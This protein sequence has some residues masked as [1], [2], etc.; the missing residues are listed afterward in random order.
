MSQALTIGDVINDI[1]ST[2]GVG[3][4]ASLNNNSIQLTDN[5]GQTTTALAVSNV[6]STATATGLGLTAASSGATLTGNQINSIGANTLLST[7]N[8]GNGVGIN[9][10]LA[11]LTV[12]RSDGTTFNVTL[13]GAKTVGDVIGKINAASGG[14]V[15]ASVNSAGTGLQLVDTSTP[16][17]TDHLTVSAANGSTAAADLGIL[18]T[19][20]GGT[21]QIV[22]SAVIASLG[23]SL[24]KNLNGGAGANLGTIAITNRSNVTTDVNLAGA[25]SI[26]DVINAINKA[27]AGV[28][29]SLNSAGNG[30]TLTDQTGATTSNLIVADVSGTGAANL[31]LA[32]SVAG[33][34]I[35]SGDLEH[36]FVAAS[37]LLSTLNGGAGVPAGSF[38][39]TDSRGVSATVN[40]TSASTTLAQVMSNI[41]SRGLD[42]TAQINAAGN[43]IE[44]LDTGPGATPI[45]VS[46]TATSTALGLAGAASAGGQPFQGSFNKTV[47]I[48][49]SD[50]LSDVVNDINNANVGIQ[51][52][53]INDGSSNNPYRLSLQ[54]TTSG[55]AGAFIVDDGGLN[56]GATTLV[57]AQNAQVFYGS[58]NPA[59]AIAISSTTNTLNNVIPGVS[60]SLDSTTQ[61]PVSVTVAADTSGVS[62]AVQSFV[63][64]FNSA[65]SSI[66]NYDRY[67][68][69]TN[70]AGA[71]F[72]N[73]VVEQI[74]S[75]LFNMISGSDSNLTGAYNNLAS[76][77][78]TASGGDSLSFNATTLNN[79]LATNP[80]AVANLF[81]LNTQSTDPV[82]GKITTTAA[83]IGTNLDNLLKNITDPNT[84]IIQETV[85]SLNTEITANNATITEYNA[86]LANERTLLQTQFNNMELSL[87]KLQSQNAALSSLAQLSGE[88]TSAPASSS[89]SSSSSGS[90]S[91]SSGG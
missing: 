42:I 34:T 65:M 82:T 66:D 62:T 77:G 8:D 83:G 19:D 80:T 87:S 9:G 38:T 73:P 1:N 21:G 46:N 61:G 32:G 72:G 24:I 35:N 58:A 4:T 5:T 29:A 39:I 59:Q 84:G 56:L 41:N 13:A 25:S 79:A 53:I 33:A 52:S 45:T 37:T 85:N 36:K 55:T 50:K 22:G 81:S 64:A 3:V 7:L 2:A 76:V 10:T 60:L 68:A 67:D 78:I 23:S 16:D 90:S 57:A 14:N 18:G 74:K 89:S 31:K 6:G 40:I 71:L 17:G 88:S 30:L 28:T 54:S 44:L 26:T 20:S 75:Q 15:T 51:A 43:G 47:T 27:G 91:S 63:S 12:K 86:R 49:A 48:G 69:A 70:T 11:D